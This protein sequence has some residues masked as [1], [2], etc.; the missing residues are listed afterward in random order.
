MDDGLEPSGALLRLA[1]ERMAS[2]KDPGEAIS[3]MV[4]FASRTGRQIAALEAR[5]RELESLCETD[6]LTGLANRR[7]LNAYLKRATSR[8]ARRGM[9]G[10]VGLFDLDGF[11]EINDRYGHDVG[12]Q[13]LCTVAA[14]LRS[15]VRD[16]D[17][18]A[19]FG[20]DEFVVVLEDVAPEV[21]RTRLVLLRDALDRSA[22]D[23][24]G[25]RVSIRASVGWSAF[26]RDLDGR[27]A[28]AEAD[29]RM[30]EDKGARS[31]VRRAA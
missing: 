5:V 7:G 22:V 15:G 14:T 23:V 18:V 6:E 21:G 19:R 25:Q 10:V 30:Y 20:G 12:D 27:D 13:V 9:G 24:G 8:A 3:E 4:A 17:C 29:A 1:R 16:M 26:G 2:R 11:K 28:V 31:R